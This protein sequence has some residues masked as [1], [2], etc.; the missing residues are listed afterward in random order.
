MHVNSH[1]LLGMIVAIAAYSLYQYPLFITTL[2]IAAAVAQDFDFLLSKWAPSNNH[3]RLFTHSIFPTIIALIIALI[4]NLSWIFFIALS[5]FTHVLVDMLDW[6]LNLF[7][8]G[9]IIGLAALL[10]EKDS[11]HLDFP[12]MGYYYRKFFFTSRYMTSK[13]FLIADLILLLLTLMLMIFTQFPWP[14]LLI[15]Y[16]VAWS[17]HLYSYSSEKKKNEALKALNLEE[18]NKYL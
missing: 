12:S 13:W 15:G 5:I 18:K 16:I 11:S 1:Y 2:I 8:N 14:F 9:T 17:Y 7:Y 4:S 10:P 3:R 6:G